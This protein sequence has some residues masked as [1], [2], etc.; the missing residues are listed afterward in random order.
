MILT[1]NEC[2]TIL[3]ITGNTYDEKLRQM[4]PYVQSDIIYYCDNPF[5]DKVIYVEDSNAFDFVRGSTSTA[6]TQADYVLDASDRFSTV[7]FTDGM[8]VIIVGGANEGVYTI[9]SVTTGTMKITSTGEFV[10]QSQ[11]T[12]YRSPGSI[13]VSRVVWPRAVKLVAA[14]MVWYLIDKPKV[15]DVKSESIDDYSVTYMGSNMYPK[16]L[17]DSL[18]PYRRAVLV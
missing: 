16:P 8:D 4:I 17:V 11:T 10:T 14:K 9:A 7:G 13:R 18:A 2:K 1:L 5:A 12:N 15:T 3:G 6:T